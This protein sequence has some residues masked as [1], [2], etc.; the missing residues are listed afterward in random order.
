MFCHRQA[1]CLVIIATFALLPAYSA[2]APYGEFE[3]VSS[4]RSIDLSTH[5]VKV[6]TLLEIKNVGTS[7]SKE[8]YIVVE[9]AIA[10]DLSF[11]AVAGSRDNDE[12][13]QIELVKPK[14]K[15]AGVLYRVQL[16]SKLEPKSQRS[17]YVYQVFRS[18]QLPYP[19]EAKQSDPQLMLVA[20]NAH[21]YSPYKVLSDSLSVKLPDTR[22]ISHS[23][24][25]P[26]SVSDNI[27]EYGPFNDVVP[28]SYQ[29]VSIHFENH[30][31]FLTVTSLL[32]WIEVSHWGGNI[33][34]EEN[35]EMKHT[36]AKL[37]GSF[38]RFDYMYL[39]SQEGISSVK[40]YKTVLPAG[41]KDV[42]Y[43]DEIG[44]IS[45]SNLLELLDAVEL[46]IRPRYPLFG[47]WITHYMLGYNLP[48]YQYLFSSG[49]NYA[50]KMRF[51]DHIFDDMSVDEVV[52][53]IILPEG[54][55]DISVNVPYAVEREEDSL[56]YTFLDFSGRPVVTLKKR[57]LVEEHIQDFE[58]R[59][60]FSSIL[61]FRE[62]LML[63][64]A[65]IILFFTVIAFVRLDF[66]ISVDSGAEAKLKVAGIIE[67][68]LSLQGKRETLYARLEDC[69]VSFRKSKDQD[70]LQV[71]RKSF[72]AEYK[73]VKNAIDAIAK[74]VREDSPDVSERIAEIQ[75][76]EALYQG[77]L[78]DT[79]KNATQVVSGGITAE[80]FKKT[81]E[82]IDQKK[83]DA[84]QKLSKV[85]AQL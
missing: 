21:V 50:L 28:L 82:A 26:F 65:L 18:L 67:Q 10:D 69:I 62:P 35:I 30:S 74:V 3:I 6:S 54:A 53:K 63:I 66:S 16:D 60:R 57:S 22:L 12:N 19:K 7:S 11:I 52:V 39:R 13:F 40:S 34:V 56:H 76:L 36:G 42:Y 81:D 84:K 55:S 20:L 48:S 51:V 46:E 17:L 77:L 47:G 41:A 61:M 38:S 73:E 58:L 72:E 37:Q 75:R 23:K 1:W 9:E 70:A 27:V 64:T 33:A 15:L 59:Y 2:P 24:I 43:R 68:L 80:A 29:E 85:L 45:T 78:N 71:A 49:S 4:E 31:P 83:V 32:R 14:S 44:N 25:E 8:F 79:V 5:L